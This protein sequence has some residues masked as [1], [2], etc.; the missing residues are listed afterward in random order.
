MAQIGLVSL[1]NALEHRAMHIDV[2]HVYAGMR[3]SSS[4][5]LSVTERVNVSAYYFS[6]Y[7]WRIS[8][9]QRQE[10][11][12]CFRHSSERPSPA[13]AWPSHLLCLVLIV[14]CL[15]QKLGAYIYCKMPRTGAF[16]LS[17]P[18]RHRNSSQVCESHLCAIGNG[19]TMITHHCIHVP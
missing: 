14:R 17:A 1:F 13:F 19:R 4:T 16:E 2:P 8:Q 3:I 11:A 7:V 12:H 15:V 10:N 6:M 18:R 9:R 5:H